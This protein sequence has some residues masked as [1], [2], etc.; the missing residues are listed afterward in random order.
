M[1]GCPLC[2]CGL[3]RGVQQQSHVNS[4][5][6]VAQTRLPLLAC[7]SSA[8]TCSLLTRPPPL[9]AYLPQALPVPLPLPVDPTQRA[10]CIS[11]LTEMGFSYPDAE[12]ATDAAGGEVETALQ[13]LTSG[14]VGGPGGSGWAG[15]GAPGTPEMGSH[16]DW[17]AHS[18]TSQP[19]SWDWASGGASLK[20]QAS[21]WGQQYAAVP[22]APAAS[23]TDAAAEA[24]AANWPYV[25]P[26]QDRGVADDH[27]VDEL[28]AM[29]LGMAC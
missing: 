6:T 21:D 15:S 12:A 25:P 13:L 10:S 3:L 14:A 1:C 23:A 22:A 7:M 16:P 26:P 8:H 2:E 11:S 19:G 20:A 18:E 9:R 29:M 17:H 27:E 28:M 24:D 5:S 4:S